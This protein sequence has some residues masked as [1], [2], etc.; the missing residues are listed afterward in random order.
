M[1]GAD[2]SDFGAVP[3]YADH[4]AIIALVEAGFTPLQAIRFATHDAAD[5]LGEGDRIGTIAVGKVAD[6]L[7]VQGAPDR[8]IDDIRKVAI[9]IK[10]G[11]AYDPEK[12][13]A[14][15]KGKLGLE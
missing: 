4:A 12:L 13:R 7:I 11:R 5:F 8:N 6:M 10:D 14:A 15:A 9:V 2:A 1:I 3:G